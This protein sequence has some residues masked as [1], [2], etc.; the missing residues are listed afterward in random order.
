MTKQKER[1]QFRLR[2]RI[3]VTVP[4]D[5]IGDCD[6]C[7]KRNDLYDDNIE[8]GNFRYCADCWASFSPEKRALNHLPA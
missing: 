4:R 6:K 1:Q 8:E 7:H 2:H 3:M 5:A